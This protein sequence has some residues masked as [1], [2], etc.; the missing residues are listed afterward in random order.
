MWAGRGRGWWEGGRN[1]FR[2]HRCRG[3]LYV[4]VRFEATLY[5][6]VSF[7]KVSVECWSV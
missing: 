7:V 4:D 2:W 3:L 1:D 6:Y 5:M